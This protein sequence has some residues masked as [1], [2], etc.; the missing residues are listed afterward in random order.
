MCG[1]VNMAAD[2][3]SLVDELDVD[4][5]RWSVPESYNV[6]PG[7]PLPI[8]LDRVDADGQLAR[9]LEAA[10]WGLVP[11]WAKDDKIGFRAFNARSET[12]DSKPMFRSAFTSRRCAVAVNGY[13][14]WEKTESG[15]RPWY[16]HADGDDWIFM[17]GLFELR[18]QPPEQADQSEADPSVLDGWL[19][20]TTML[21]LPARGHLEQ[22]HHRMPL[23][24]ERDQIG[25]WLNPAVDSKADTGQLLEGLLEGVEPDRIK[26]YAVG[27]EVGNVRNNWPGLADPA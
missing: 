9:R 16:M 12:V 2:P 15:K 23:F 6:P 20:S 25:Q 26:R 17:A 5:F 13:Y 24:L 27:A 14:E 11:G 1:R 4:S 21:T 7:S 19:V 10:R 22:V 3:A 8:I 18:Q